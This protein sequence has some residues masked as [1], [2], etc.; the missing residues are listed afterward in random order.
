M[1]P[2]GRPPSAE[3]HRTKAHGWI[4]EYGVR[5]S[6]GVSRSR[7]PAKLL[8]LHRETMQRVREAH[9]TVAG[10]LIVGAN[11]ATCLYVLPQIFAEFKRKHPQVGISIYRSFSH[12]ILQK[13]AESEVDVGIVTLPVSQN[14][15]KVVPIFEDELYVVVPAGHPMAKRAAVKIEDLA[16]EPLIFPKGGHTRELL[17]RLFRK[18]RN[19]LQISMRSEER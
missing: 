19:Q 8:A 6:N 13:M 3:S 16:K 12:K 11:E 14:N 5:S 17:E 15:L 7:P 18:Y 2:H 9:G 10:K 4:G 1:I